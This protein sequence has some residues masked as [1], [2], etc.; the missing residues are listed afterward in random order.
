MYEK[1]KFNYEFL[2]GFAK[3][4]HSIATAELFEYSEEPISMNLLITNFISD[5]GEKE[6][7]NLKN[8]KEVLLASEKFLCKL[9]NHTIAEARSDR[10]YRD[11][12]M[13]RQILCFIGCQI[14]TEQNVA[15]ILGMTRNS[16][17]QRKSKALLYYKHHKPFMRLTDIV[18]TKFGIQIE[19]T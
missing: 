11:I 1:R 6:V 9:C 19:L 7:Y 13:I 15:D 16:V 17:H 3:Y 5:I 14:T 18:C 8:S 10:R 12:P 4:Y 2:I